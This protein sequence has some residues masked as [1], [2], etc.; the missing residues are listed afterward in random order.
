MFLLF[1]PL[2]FVNHGCESDIAFAYLSTRGNMK[3][4]RGKQPLDIPKGTQIEAGEEVLF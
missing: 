2:Q 1:G 3:L 4:V